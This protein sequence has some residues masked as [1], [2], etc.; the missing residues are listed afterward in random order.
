MIER[1]DSGMGEGMNDPLTVIQLKE[2]P[3]GTRYW[4]NRVLV[5]YIVVSG[6]VDEAEGYKDVVNLTTG[7]LTRIKDDLTVA[8]TRNYRLRVT[9]EGLSE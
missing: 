1:S 5:E 9:K 8:R 3:P 7:K 6:F 4:D 2:L